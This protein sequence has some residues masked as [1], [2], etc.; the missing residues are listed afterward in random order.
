[1]NMRLNS[2]KIQLLCVSANPFN[3]IR[4]YIRH[5]NKEMRSV[6][7]L[8]ILSFWFVSIL[9]CILNA[10]EMVGVDLLR[11]VPVKMTIWISRT[12]V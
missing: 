6:D 7:E 11:L 8:K 10:R 5:E 4:S 1:M 2:D 12:V 9:I 3:V